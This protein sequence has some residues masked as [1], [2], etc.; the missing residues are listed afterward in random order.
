MYKHMESMSGQPT[1]VKIRTANRCKTQLT[2]AEKT[3]NRC[4]TQLTH[5]E[6]TINRY[7]TQ[8][9]HAEKQ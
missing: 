9:T 1:N 5:A 2:H 7:K 8:L 6:K 4:K 3:I